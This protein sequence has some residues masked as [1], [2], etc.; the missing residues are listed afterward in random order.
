MYRLLRSPYFLLF[1]WLVNWIVSL[2][3]G[4]VIYI[5]NKLHFYELKI[6]QVNIYVYIYCN[7]EIINKVFLSLIHK[8]LMQFMLQILYNPLI[9]SLKEMV[10]KFFY[11]F[12]SLF[13]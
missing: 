8:S 12:I 5:Y 4:S 1:I 11:T 10:N 2:S 3:D 6:T 9:T 7:F 13:T